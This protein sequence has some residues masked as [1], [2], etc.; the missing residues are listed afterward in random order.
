MQTKVKVSYPV[1]KNFI[2]DKQYDGEFMRKYYSEDEVFYYDATIYETKQSLDNFS[3]EKDILF[4][5]NYSDTNYKKVIS[6][7]KC[8]YM[9]KKYQVYKNDILMFERLII[10]IKTSDKDIAEITYYSPQNEIPNDIVNG[11]ID[12]ITVTKD[13]NY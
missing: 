10:Y 2:D 11:I 13:T 12:N 4:N 5:E 8:K 9:C 1:L 7:I 6:D 3:K